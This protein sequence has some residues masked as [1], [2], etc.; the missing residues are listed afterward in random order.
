MPLDIQEWSQELRLE[1]GS[2]AL[3]HPLASAF[4]FKRIGAEGNVITHLLSTMLLVKQE[5]VE[6]DAMFRVGHRWVERVGVIN[7]VKSVNVCSWS[8]SA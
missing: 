3:F 5:E 1:L 4:S 8:L 6:S 7:K 2:L